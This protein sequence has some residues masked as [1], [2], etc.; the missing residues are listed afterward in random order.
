[1]LKLAAQ[2]TGGLTVSL[3]QQI[4]GKEG[5][6]GLTIANG[7][8]FRDD[9]GSNHIVL[10]QDQEYT[11]YHELCHVLESCI[12]TRSP[13][14]E[15]WDLLNPPGFSYDGN[16]EDY[17]SRADSPYLHPENRAFIDSYSMSFPQEDRARIMEY[18]MTDGHSQLFESPIMQ[19][20][21]SQLSLGIRQAF[22][23]E[24]SPAVFL[25]EQYLH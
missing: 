15:S 3:V 11:L 25:W 23:L 18:A 13:A 12:I 24:Q 14:F 19:E 6:G 21:L 22:G 4:R 7:L 1:M 2:D 9:R 16:Y 10:A 20:K 17:R 5:N 8:Q